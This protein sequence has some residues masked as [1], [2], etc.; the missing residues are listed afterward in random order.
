VAVA[1]VPEVCVQQLPRRVA[2]VRLNLLF[3]WR[4]QQITQLQLV[5]VE[6]QEL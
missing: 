2:V 6:L 4:Y 5:A 1:E 3:L